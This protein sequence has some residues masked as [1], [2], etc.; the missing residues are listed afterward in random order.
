MFSSARQH[1]STLSWWDVKL[2][3]DYR[4]VGVQRDSYGDYRGPRN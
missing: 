4:W 2:V 3:A 1:K